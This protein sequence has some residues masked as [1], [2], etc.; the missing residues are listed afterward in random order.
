VEF[1]N[2]GGDMSEAMLHIYDV[3]NN[4][5]VQTINAIVQ[6]NKIMKCEIDVGGIFHNV[7]DIYGEESSFGFCENGTGVFNCPPKQNPMYTY[8]ESILLGH[9]HL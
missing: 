9:S 7:V 8:R 1:S 2:F 5:Y 4:K 3:T 6:L